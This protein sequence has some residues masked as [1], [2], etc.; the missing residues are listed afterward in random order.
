MDE[1]NLYVLLTL[2]AFFIIFILICVWFNRVHSDDAPSAA[3]K[4]DSADTSSGK[5]AKKHPV[6]QGE[7]L[8]ILYSCPSGSCAAKC[9]Y[10][11]GEN[12][13]RATLCEVCGQPIPKGGAPT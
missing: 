5:A 3:A 1:N 2:C 6:S 9:P 13:V 11:D 7:P 4:P 8:V 10:C 12:S